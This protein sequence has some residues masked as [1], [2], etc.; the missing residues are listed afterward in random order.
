MG[1]VQEK[2]VMY[3]RAAR[4]PL[5]RRDDVVQ[6]PYGANAKEVD[7]LGKQSLQCEG[8]FVGMKADGREEQAGDDPYDWQ[9]Q[10]ERTK[11]TRID[12]VCSEKESEREI[13]ESPEAES[14]FEELP[15]R[16]WHPVVQEKGDTCHQEKNDPCQP[17]G[18]DLDERWRQH[19]EY[20]QVSDVPED[21]VG[22]KTRQVRAV[23]AKKVPCR[24]Q[25]LV[26]VRVVHQ[27]PAGHVVAEHREW[28]YGKHVDGTPN[29]IWDQKGPDAFPQRL[30]V[31]AVS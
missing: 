24:E 19:D 1:G 14:R 5:R 21:S 18:H 3:E 22:G 29:Q 6:D 23:D 11:R 26:E 8:T 20:Q 10:P 9:Q 2:R 15:A 28:H 16:T 25:G 30:R 27:A 4:E 12:R 31:P 7:R 17:A 13:E